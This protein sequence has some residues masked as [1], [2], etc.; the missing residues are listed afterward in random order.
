MYNTF[1][2]VISYNFGI[3]AIIL[4]TIISPHNKGSARKKGWK[5]KMP[6]FFI[7][8]FA[9]ENHMRVD[10]KCSNFITNQSSKIE[11][12]FWLRAITPQ[13]LF[14][15]LFYILISLYNFSSQNPTIFHFPKSN[16]F[17]S[18]FKKIPYHCYNFNWFLCSWSLF[19]LNFMAF[20]TLILFVAFSN[21]FFKYL[22]KVLI[23]A[24][25]VLILG[26]NP[27]LV[28]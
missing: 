5:G 16:I 20:R 26:K 15:L 27:H 1:F 3:F 4:A 14:N 2:R 6:L 17:D 7:S 19:S 23:F 12:F 28:A 8:K 24:S 10:K 13:S 22:Q 25:F 11:I 9:A 18:F 21:C